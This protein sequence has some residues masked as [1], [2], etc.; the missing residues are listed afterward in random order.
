MQRD[1]TLMAPGLFCMQK[2]RETGN[3][4]LPE[5]RKKKGK[6]KII[7][8]QPFTAPSI[9]PWTIC[10]WPK[11]KTIIMGIMASNAAAMTMFHS[12]T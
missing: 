7:L 9:T 11:R 3:P 2:N 5:V 6:K 4:G 10:F 12:V 8:F 1:P